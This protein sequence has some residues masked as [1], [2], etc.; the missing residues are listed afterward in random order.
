[1]SGE[2]GNRRSAFQVEVHLGEYATAEEALTEWPKQIARLRE[3][4]RVTKA[5][6]LEG[7]LIKLRRL[8]K[9]DQDAGQG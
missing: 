9:G 7:K 1:M 6:R 4:G 3:V 2:T 8:T 5:N